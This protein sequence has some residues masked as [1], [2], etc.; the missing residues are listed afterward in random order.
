MWQRWRGRG[1]TAHPP[2]PAA[3]AAPAATPLDDALPLIEV[4]DHAGVRTVLR[5]P[6]L[7]TAAGVL[8]LGQRRP[9]VPLQADPDRH[10]MLRSVMDPVFSPVAVRAHEAELRRRAAELLREREHRDSVDLNERLAR[11]LPFHALS[12]LLDLDTGIEQLRELHDG[13]L[14]PA[15]VAADRT[16]VGDR[17]WELFAPVVVD[18]RA[19]NGADLIS[20]LQRARASGA[21]IA[22]DDIT[23]LCYLLLLA[24]IDPVVRALSSLFAHLAPLVD[25]RRALLADVES[26]RG[27]V[28]EL[29][30]WSGGVSQ[31]TRGATA[32]TEVSG[33]AVAPGQ[34]VGC[35]IAE[36]NRD[37]LAFDRPD[38][39]DP[40]RSNAAHLAFGYGAHR[41]IGAHL[42]RLEL[43]VAAEV[44]EEELPGYRPGPGAF[45]PADDPAPT[46]PLVVVFDP[47]AH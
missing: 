40:G 25:D 31:L 32:A 14:G 28:E 42:A 13:I 5:D 1:R 45:P 3:P 33:R 26:M 37:P 23:S 46:S 35:L 30:R 38:R 34:R 4:R 12:T 22:E 18:R 16:L 9:L 41:C 11:R 10:P 44:A 47:A 24:G 15:A 27:T 19:G 21:P 6:A 43:V 17:I 20:T 36:A 39:F 7:F 8:D 2:A 29:L